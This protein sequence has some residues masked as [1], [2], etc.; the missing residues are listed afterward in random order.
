MRILITGGTGFIGRHLVPML[1]QHQVMQ[2]SR[3]TGSSALTNLKILK[4]DLT[5]PDSW[6]NQ[7]K[8]FSPDTC[9]HLAWLGLPDYS[10]PKCIENFDINMD[11]LDFLSNIECQRIII[12]G[13][14]WE[15]G[16]LQGKVSESDLPGPT[17]LFASFKSSIRIIGEHLAN[18]KGVELLW[19]RIFFVYGEGQRSTS[20]I[21]DCYQSFKSGRKPEI[22]SPYDVNDFIHVSDVAKAISALIETPAISGVFNIGSGKPSK[23][24]DVCNIISDLLNKEGVL[25]KSENSTKASGLWADISRIREKTGWSPQHTIQTGLA[26]TLHDFQN[27]P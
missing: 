2:I 23:V 4:A 22:K 14:C 19:G 18:S 10:F 5:C 16:D 12:A 26:K 24:I 3:E 20:L 27:N 15:Y 8:K 13:T 6:K 7:V 9:I 17:N 11:L 21:P 25:Q 1:D